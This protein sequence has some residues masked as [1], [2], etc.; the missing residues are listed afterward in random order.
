MGGWTTPGDLLAGA[1]SPHPL[2]PRLP[3]QVVSAPPPPAQ[4]GLV[5]PRLP[6]RCWVSGEIEAGALAGRCRP[7]SPGAPSDRQLNR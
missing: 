6:L 2:S 3:L 5:A 4:L 1:P 7:R